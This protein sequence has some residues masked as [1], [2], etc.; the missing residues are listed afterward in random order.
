MN[1]ATLGFDEHIQELMRWVNH[2]TDHRLVAC[3][4]LPTTPEATELAGNAAT[5]ESW[6]ALL[7]K[8][9]AD[10]V[11]VAARPRHDADPE[12]RD[13]Q[14]RKLVQAAI[15]LILVHPSCEMLMGLELEMI[16]Q[17]SQ[18]VM[19]PYHSGLWDWRYR[20]LANVVHGNSSMGEPLGK[21]E[22][23]VWERRASQRDD[24]AVMNH[25]SHDA[26]MLRDLMSNVTH[27]SAAGAVDAKDRY[28]NLSV[29]LTGSSGLIARWSIVPAQE[30]D[31]AQLTVIGSSGSAVLEMPQFGPYALSGAFDPPEPS[32]SR[33]AAEYVFQ[34]LQGL[35]AEGTPAAE[36]PWEASCR[37]LEI[38]DAAERSCRRRRTIELF[39]EKV[40]ERETFKSM[41]AA[42]G[43]AMLMW[44][45]FMLMVAGIVEGLKLPIRE[46]TFWQLWS[47]ILFTPLVIFLLLQLL[48]S[49]E[50]PREE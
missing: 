37:T 18:C 46:S 17:D 34:Q 20:Q 15:P 10:V 27:V 23:L 13:D 31:R 45:L 16:R 47:A 11:L 9:I 40:T 41:M 26:M 50:K 8:T 22:Q 3:F 4:D 49:R 7:S 21:V 39:H 6:E 5:D 35:L 29:N 19:I 38:E 30:N 25:F 48:L 33:Q 2:S 1:V 12:R 28:A 36:S 43:C 14:L 24:A 44:V 32:S 42:G